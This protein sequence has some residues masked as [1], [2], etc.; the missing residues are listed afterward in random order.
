TIDNASNNNTFMDHL[1]EALCEHKVD[2]DKV[3]NCLW[4][5]PHIVNIACQ[6]IIAK[7]SK[8][9]AQIGPNF[10]V[11]FSA[12][13]SPTWPTY[14]DALESNLIKRCCSFINACCSSGG[15]RKAL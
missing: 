11:P 8:S 1:E 12:T 5:F 14:Q 4:C 7:F 9:E 15:C 2:F 13:E 6:H 3:G 10:G